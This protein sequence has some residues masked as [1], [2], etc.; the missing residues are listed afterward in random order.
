M[1]FIALMVLVSNSKLRREMGREGKDYFGK[2]N[3][4]RNIGDALME[5]A[6]GSGPFLGI[7]ISDGLNV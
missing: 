2:E 3:L 4:K 7:A 1:W 6:L 5:I